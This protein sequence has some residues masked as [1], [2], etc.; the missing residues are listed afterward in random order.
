[1]GKTS[2]W[3]KTGWAKTGEWLRRRV[4]LLLTL[5]LV[6]AITIAIF[7]YRDRVAELGNFGYLGAFLVSLIGNATIL[8]PITVVP[9][10]CAIGVALYPVTGLV[11]PILVALA[12]GMGAGIGE[13]AGYMVGYSGRGVIGNRKM[14]LRL[15][16]WMKRWGALAIFVGALVPFFF[17]IVGMAAGA[18][19]FPLWKYIL[20]CWLGR[21]LNYLAFTLLAA[22]WGWEL[23]LRYV[24]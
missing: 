18:L 8:L 12:G 15:V 4:I 3:V 20:A 19:R 5:F 1:M 2:D 13:I 17:D 21:S 10:L 24:G 23:W 11:G 14:Y 9:I 6:I 22:V 7:I 16:G